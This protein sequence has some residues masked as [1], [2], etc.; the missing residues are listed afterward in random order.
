[1]SNS[2]DFGVSVHSMGGCIKWAGT[3]IGGVRRSP[4][5]SRPNTHLSPV[6]EPPGS[7][8]P[9][10]PESLDI[11]FIGAAPFTH[12]A[13]QKGTQVHRIDPCR[14]SLYKAPCETDL[15]L[16]GLKEDDFKNLLHG[17]STTED[18]ARFPACFQSFIKDH[19]DK[20]FLNRMTEE[21]IDKFL[22]VKEPTSKEEILKKL[23][24]EYHEF[25]EVFLP[26]EAEKLPPH[27]PFDHK[28][29][30]KPGEEPPYYRN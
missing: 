23:P 18:K 21:D 1:M 10:D 17:K 13:R 27:R 14:L 2:K 26:K 9:E 5:K 29:E 8:T 12:F 20:I 19:E 6:K 24:A 16:N 28:I 7:T 15:A 22:K 4:K 30:L 11:R 3:L 25:I